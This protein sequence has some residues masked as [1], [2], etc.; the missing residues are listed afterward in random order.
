MRILIINSEYSPVGGGAGNASANLAQNFANRDHEVTVLTSQFRNLPREEIWYGVRVIRALAWRKRIDRSKVHEQVT[1]ILGG[2]MRALPLLFRWRP[3]V[4]LAFFGMPGGA[5]ALPI[6]L[7]FNIPFVVS[8]RGG[9]V[10]G[11]R[12]Y[13]FATYHKLIS[14]LLRI[15]WHQAGA[16]VANSGG[17]RTMAQLFERRVPIHII[18]NG[19]DPGYFAPP[20]REW[21]P[22]RLL[23]V[24]RIVYQKGLDL[25]L[26]ALSTLNGIPWELVVVGDG[27]Q[28]ENLQRLAW[29]LEIGERVRF[30]GWKKGEELLKEYHR[31][32]LFPY[33]SRHEGMPNAVLEAMASGL[34]VIAS[35][36]A[37][38]EEL[39]I[40]EETGLL[41]EP[42]NQQ[43]LEKALLGLLTN[44]KKRQIMGDAGRQRTIDC[45]PWEQ[46]AEKYLHL[47]HRVA[48]GPQQIESPH[49]ET[50]FKKQG[51]SYRKDG[52]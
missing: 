46:I 13:D 5:I 17:L 36:I 42:D 44:P 23:F 27:P 40:H 52:R 38:N 47:L 4:I 28:R 35:R 34:P 7:L 32:N 2:G 11:F 33:P 51:D 12:P 14:P 20:A 43:A 16:V 1:F 18:P 25:L 3:D 49:G 41:I 10:P 37:G 31:A 6:K 30:R 24:G 48:S 45:Y 29:T 19:V 50:G 15:I 22:P 21:D 9:D 8:L 26:H 39:V